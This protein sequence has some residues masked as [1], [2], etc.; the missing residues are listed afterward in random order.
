MRVFW[1][2]LSLRLRLFL[3]FGVLFAVMTGLTLVLQSS[4][5]AQ[6]RI[7]S[8]LKDELP[9][10]LEHLGAQVA[11]KLAPSLQVSRSF[12]ANTFIQR[13][14]QRGMPE[15]DL[16]LLADEMA[17]VNTQLNAAAVFLAANDGHSI[18]YFHFKDGEFNRRPML[19]GAAENAW[20]FNYLSS[21]LPYELNLDSNAFTGEQL[22]MFVN[23]TGTAFNANGEPVSVAGVGLDMLQL[24][25]M[26]SAYRVGA[27][28]RA[29][30]ANQDGLIEVSA[31][32]ALITDMAAS[33]ELK[34]LLNQEKVQVGEIT[35]NDQQLFVGVVWLADLQRYLVVE[36]PRTDFMA[37][38]EQQL[39]Q[40]LLIGAVLLLI[41]LVFLYPLAV[42]LS[43]PLQIFQRQLVDIT[44]TLNL[45]QRLE[46][47]DKAELGELAAQTNSLLERLAFAIS[48]VQSSSARLTDTANNLAATAGLVSR[49]TDRQQ[50]VSQSMAAAV[51][52]MSS[53]VAEITS[54]MEELSASSTQIAD[55]SQSVVDVANL[56]LESS[57]KGANAMQHLQLRM[58]DI[59]QDSENSL[60]EIVQLG[61]KSKEIS[62]VMDLINTLA[63]QTK[64]I[65]FNAAL[66]ASSAGESGKRFS[67]VASE[68]RRLADSVTDSTHE[69]EERIQEIQDSIN[70]LVITSEKGANSIQLGMQVSLDTAED[71]NALVQAASKT[72]S[73]AQQISLSTRQQKTA[74]SQVVIALRDIA[75][76][77]T[78][79][80]QSVRQITEISEDMISM[81]EDL[82][83]LVRE[84]HLAEPQQVQIQA[85]NT[86]TKKQD[87]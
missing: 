73:A 36:V 27:H 84:F 58:A 43:R 38:I 49:N 28:G 42:S 71:L 87:V 26:I 12:A 10:Q 86:L 54:T 81:S 50:E 32:D 2:Q 13:W 46:T 25:E 1:N 57:K 7:E 17:V 45:S 16:P 56:T 52:E 78:H 79:N 34:A 66:E 61:S 33:T 4:F 69:I 5:Y 72:S 24:A 18:Q 9:L 44:R 67:V 37:P 51:E 85:L 19:R 74:S 31:D 64:L 65:A 30:L 76:A 47:T 23:Y 6:S 39:Y 11:L 40:A 75:N 68:I 59:H 15:A 70:R 20:Y 22:Q 35:Y 62:K 63:A 14:I 48:G 8:L 80:A 77:S 41:S 83:Y 29:S 21:Q 60:Q 3:S 82:S 55:Y 53:S